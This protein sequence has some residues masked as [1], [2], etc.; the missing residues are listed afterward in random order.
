MA[1][2]AVLFLLCSSSVV[3]ISGVHNH[4]ADEGNGILLISDMSVLVSSFMFLKFSKMVVGVFDVIV[5]KLSWKLEMD[6]WFGIFLVWIIYFAIFMLRI[7]CRGGSPA[8]HS[9]LSMGL[10]LKAPVERRIP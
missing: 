8:L 7:I 5:W 3:F 10:V 9:I 1:E 2:A 4:G 6:M